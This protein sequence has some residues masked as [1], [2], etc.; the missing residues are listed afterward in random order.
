MLDELVSAIESDFFRN[1]SVLVGITVAILSIVSARITAI[2][3][4]SADVMFGVRGDVQFRDG[5][6]CIAKYHNATDSN[7]RAFATEQMRGHPDISC[8]MYAL[9]YFESLSVG[10]QAGIYSEEMFKRSYCSTLTATYERALPLIKAIREKAKKAT[11][12]QE[13]SWLAER[14]IANPL[15][16]KGQVGKKNWLL[17]AFSLR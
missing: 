8:I 14:W 3:K 7:I 5:V 16:V 12:Y 17:R 6:L 15:P 11:T 1:V 4:Q 9:N 10:I 13:F 2:K